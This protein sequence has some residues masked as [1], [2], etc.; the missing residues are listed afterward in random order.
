MDQA[1]WQTY[2]KKDITPEI[3]IEGKEMPVMDDLVDILGGIEGGENLAIRLSKFTQ[4]TF[5]GLFNQRTNVE[6]NNQLVVFSVRDLEDS[7]R[8]I[9]IHIIL[10]F[11]WNEVRSQLKRRI[12]VVDE[13][14]WMM[15][16]DDSARFLFGIAKRAR[17][18]YLGVT[19]ITQDVTDFLQSP[20]GEPIVTNSS[21]QLLLKQSPASMELLSKVFY[22]TQGEKYLLLESEVGEGLFFAGIKHVAIKIVA[23]YIEDQIITTD[24][25]QVIEIEEAKKQLKNSA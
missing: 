22:L 7:L 25:K 21:M 8:P 17:K 13:A 6:L 20:Y 14:W 5:A 18:Y 11:I 19:T 24:P 15:Q 12:L 16:N 3:G 2:A 23:S 1:L 4:G 10:N 9:A